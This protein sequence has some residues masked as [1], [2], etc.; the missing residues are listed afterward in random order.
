MDALREFLDEVNKNQYAL[1]NL[2]GL[3]QIL[4][5][6]RIAKADGSLISSGFTWRDLSAL[7][8]KYR[9][10]TGGV[11]E[12][13]LNP[14][15]LPLRDRQRF[16]YGVIVRAKVDTVEAAQAGDRLAEVLRQHGFVI[17]SSHPPAS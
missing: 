13:G 2:L 4:I 15:D 11:G 12:L 5:G 8:K 1:G 6:R 9:W 14:D 17:S 16:W 10:D 3:L 7:L